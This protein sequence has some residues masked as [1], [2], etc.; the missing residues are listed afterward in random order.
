[1]NE[2]IILEKVVPVI[3]LEDICQDRDKVDCTPSQPK[4]YDTGH[5]ISSTCKPRLL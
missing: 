4:F 5:P 3:D 1:M 2:A